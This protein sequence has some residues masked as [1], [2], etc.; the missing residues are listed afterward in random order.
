[1]FAQFKLYVL[2]AGAALIAI[3][4]AT[5]AWKVQNWRYGAMETARVEQERET[6]VMRRKAANNASTGHEQD[7]VRIQ[8]EYVTIEKEVERVIDKIEYRDR[9]CLD[10][11]GVRVVN[12]AIRT[13]AAA[14]EPS[15]G[16]PSP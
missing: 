14:S 7:R 16:V 11:D 9:A 8:T 4:S 6:A 12:A 10:D 3:T 15:N 13:T 1:M 5:A 2:V